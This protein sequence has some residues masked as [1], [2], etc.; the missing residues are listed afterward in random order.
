[1]H[2]S[3]QLLGDYYAEMLKRR[4][5]PMELLEHLIGDR[6]A[7]G[8]DEELGV[9]NV[10]ASGPRHCSASGGVISTPSIARV[11]SMSSR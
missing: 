4:K 9:E 2:T 10:L 8:I 1:M 6:I 3:P 5:G 7:K 11:P